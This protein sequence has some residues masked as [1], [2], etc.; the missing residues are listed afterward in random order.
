MVIGSGKKNI[1]QKNSRDISDMIGV[2]VVD[3][4]VGRQYT[5]H[6]NANTPDAGSS[7]RPE[8]DRPQG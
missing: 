7:R 8:S 4:F 5:R 2:C 6:G 1:V 3:S